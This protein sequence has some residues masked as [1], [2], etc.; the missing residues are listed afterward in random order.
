VSTPVLHLLAGPN[1]SGKT[2]FFE[3]VLGPILHLP[4]LNTDALAAERW[5]GAESAH[6][7]DAS[8][9]TAR[10]RDQRIEQRRSFATE[11]VFSHPSKVE[12]VERARAAGY[13]VT[14]HLMLVPEEL[15]VARVAA[16][17]EHGGHPVP[18]GKIRERYH[19]LWPLLVT[20]VGVAD[21][22]TFY[23][24][25]RPGR[26]RPVAEYRSGVPI[27]SPDWPVWTP[28][29]LTRAPSGRRSGPGPRRKEP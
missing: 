25:S 20:A 12:L 13:L 11:T 21:E 27:A 2:T 6:A 3:H 14:L 24:T 19:R 18:E 9:E 29:A 4:F 17:V 7:Y 22:A 1:G 10:Q 15:A 23:D 26:F 5:P 16:R 28:P 8:R